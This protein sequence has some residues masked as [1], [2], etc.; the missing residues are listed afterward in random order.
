MNTTCAICT[1]LPP[2]AEMAPNGYVGAPARLVLIADSTYYSYETAS[3]G[4]TLLHA[5]GRGSFPGIFPYL[6]CIIGP[7][8]CQS[9]SLLKHR[10]VTV[11]G[12]TSCT[13]RTLMLNDNCFLLCGYC[14]KKKRKKAYVT[15]AI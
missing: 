13:N 7:S 5:C 9:V 12:A 3:T 6:L 2:K 11:E 10:V 15:N 8:V 4:C 14:T 1:F